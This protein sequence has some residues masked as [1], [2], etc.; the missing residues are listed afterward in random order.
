MKRLPERLEKAKFDYIQYYEGLGEIGEIE[1]FKT[2]FSNG[3]I[4]LWVDIKL[5]KSREHFI[6]FMEKIN[7][8]C[9]PFWPAIYS[10]KAYR[11][12]S[13]RRLKNTDEIASNG[14]WL[15]SGP[16]K[17]KSD[18]ERVISEIKNYFRKH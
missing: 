6:D 10:Q 8:T 1:F 18:I 17:S 14:L 4:P 7:I 3:N 2:N 11:K 9:R 12:Y 16:G 15:P 5:K 13:T